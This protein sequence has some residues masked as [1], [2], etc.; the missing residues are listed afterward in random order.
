[1]GEFHGSGIFPRSSLGLLA[2]G[3]V[4]L[5]SQGVAELELYSGVGQGSEGEEE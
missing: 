3:V 1:V 4:V 5:A 2:L